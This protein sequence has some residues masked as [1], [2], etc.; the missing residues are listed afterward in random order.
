MT[1]GKLSTIKKAKS[2]KL[3]AELIQSSLSSAIDRKNHRVAK[4]ISNIYIVEHVEI[5]LAL[6]ECGFL[7]NPE[8]ASLL[9]KDDY[10]DRLAWGIFVGISNY[11]N[12]KL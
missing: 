5:P 10:Q 6:V 2:G 4:S 3:L 9:V 12:S 8:E 1:V 11:F 7:S